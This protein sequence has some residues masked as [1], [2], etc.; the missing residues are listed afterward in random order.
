MPPATLGPPDH[1]AN[2]SRQPRP[3]GPRQST[4][5]P[6]RRV[7]AA[8]SLAAPGRGLAHT[9]S[10]PPGGRANCGGA[11]PRPDASRLRGGPSMSAGRHRQA[12]PSR[13]APHRTPGSP[14]TVTTG[15]RC[16][17]R[18]F[19]DVGAAG[20]TVGGEHSRRGHANGMPVVMLRVGSRNRGGR[21]AGRP[22]CGWLGCCLR[23]W[24]SRWAAVGGCGGGVPREGRARSGRWLRRWAAVGGCAR[25]VTEVAGGAAK[26]RPIPVRVGCDAHWGAVATAAVGTAVDCRQCTPRGAGRAQPAGGGRSRSNHPPDV[27]DTSNTPTTARRVAR[28]RRPMGCGEAAPHQP[29]TQPGGP[30]HQ[31]TTRRPRRGRGQPRGA[32]PRRSAQPCRPAARYAGR[33]G[34]ARQAH[35]RRRRA[36]RPAPGDRPNARGTEGHLRQGQ[37]AARNSE[38]VAGRWWV[39]V[40]GS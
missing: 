4:T 12:A 39:T 40:G 2:R 5:G 18:R 15:A 26:P 31:T 7:G 27:S 10:D 9:N 14:G 36:A 24:A 28:Q 13:W 19:R 3:G 6:P 20:I 17:V 21:P 22:C 11:G 34:A 30:R 33:P 38:P 1:A 32:Q 35:P 23:L 16:A 37:G 29:R 8:P 25:A